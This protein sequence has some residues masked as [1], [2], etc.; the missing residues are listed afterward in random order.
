MMKIGPVVPKIILLKCLFKKEINAS[1][2]YYSPRGMHAA[3]AKT[4]RACKINKTRRVAVYLETLQY[5]LEESVSHR[6]TRQVT[7]LFTYLLMHKLFNTGIQ[8][9]LVSHACD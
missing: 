6:R 8:R 9:Y 7:Q 4:V 5:R 1:R 3:R 2:T